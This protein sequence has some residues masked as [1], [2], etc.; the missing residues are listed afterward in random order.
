MK[1]YILYSDAVELQHNIKC[2]I[3]HLAIYL[4]EFAQHYGIK[5]NEVKYKEV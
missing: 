4:L 1:D 3:T 2:P 5:L